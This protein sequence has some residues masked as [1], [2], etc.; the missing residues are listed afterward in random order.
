[1]SSKYWMQIFDR[2]KG[3][4]KQRDQQILVQAHPLQYFYAFDVEDPKFA[5]YRSLA[6]AKDD[7]PKAPKQHLATL[8][9]VGE[10]SDKENSQ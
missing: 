6:E 1:M 7:S 9:A 8:S 5:L 2:F 10:S 4:S 3:Q